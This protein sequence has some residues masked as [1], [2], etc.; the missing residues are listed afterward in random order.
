V[1]HFR[2]GVWIA[3][4]KHRLGNAAK[5]VVDKSPGPWESWK[6]MTRHGRAIKFMETFCILPKGH[7]HGQPMQ[8]AKWQK[9]FLEEVLAD[10]VRAGIL[11]I[12]RGNGKS[13]LMSG[14]STWAGFDSSDS[15]Q[16]QVPIIAT[17][18]QQAIRSVYGVTSQ[19]VS[20]HPDLANRANIYTAIGANKIKVYRTG[21]EIFPVSSDIDGLQGLDPSLAIADEIGFLS[22]ESWDSLLLA[23]GKRPHST[24]IGTGTPGLD[25]ENALFHVRQRVMEGAWIPGFYYKEYSADDGCDIH[26]LKQWKKA[27]PALDAGYLSLDALETALA[28]SPASHF[29]VFR[30][31]QWYDGTD[32]WLGEDGRAVWDRLADPTYSLIPGAPTWVGID[33]GLK[34]DSTAVVAVQ[35]RDNA[36]LHAECKIWM[37]AKDTP[38]DVTDVMAYL[39]DLSNNYKVGAISFDPRFFDV[40]AKMLYDDGLPMVEIPQ[41]V[42]RMTP[43]IGNLYEIILKE[44][45]SHKGDTAFTTQ[46]L[47][48]VPRINERGFTLQKS[49]S[50]GRIDAAIALALAVDRAQHRSKPRPPVV[51]L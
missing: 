35:Y 48:A 38:V 6:G 11:Q 21:G 23:S 1:G 26:D 31:A 12:A 49:K 15:G 27:N 34:R 18:V 2:R 46:V 28:L 30:L 32:S 37:P 51:V 17:T 16:P 39:R 5:K 29:R 44:G 22:V 50:R 33:V 10:H 24:V 4:D 20:T 47:N 13:T 45:L 25:R 9:E 7:G 14:L 3:I 19:M 42:E 40:P 36:T 43:I 41:S 8:L